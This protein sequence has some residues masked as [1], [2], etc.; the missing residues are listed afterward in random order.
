[1][2]EVELNKVTVNS[3]FFTFLIAKGFSLEVLKHSLIFLQGSEMILQEN[4]F[5]SN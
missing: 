5:R 2:T 4:I 3:C 1:M